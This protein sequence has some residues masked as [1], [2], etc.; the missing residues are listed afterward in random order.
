MKKVF[1]VCLT[2]DIEI[3]E[4]DEDEH[5]D[6]VGPDGAEAILRDFQY[7]L[8]CQFMEKGRN[9]RVTWLYSCHL[10]YR[11]YVEYKLLLNPKQTQKRTA[12]RE[13]PSPIN[14]MICIDVRSAQQW[15]ASSLRVSMVPDPSAFH[16]CVLI[17]A[18]EKGNAVWK[19]KFFKTGHVHG[20]T[21]LQRADMLKIPKDSYGSEKRFTQ[22]QEQRQAWS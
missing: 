5:E 8:K 19:S 16:E 14:V 15:S 9:L 11:L 22:S 12:L 21:M 13:P 3:D 4:D 20:V 17:T 2:G 18:N 10:F 6:K 7:Q 1:N